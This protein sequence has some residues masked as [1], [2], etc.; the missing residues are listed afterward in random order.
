MYQKLLKINTAVNQWDMKPTW[1]QIKLTS[2]SKN[3]K[4]LWCKWNWEIKRSW[5]KHV[6][7][8]A[9]SPAS[10]DIIKW[11]KVTQPATVQWRYCDRH[12]VTDCSAHHPTVV[13]GLQASHITS[14]SLHMCDCVYC[15]LLAGSSWVDTGGW[16]AMCAGDGI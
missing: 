11:C 3:R 15:T 7:P 1:N 4:K 16:R 5:T 13:F 10:H 8:T 14:H 2:L 6:S 9:C 12:R